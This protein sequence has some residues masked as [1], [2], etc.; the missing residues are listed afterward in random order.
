MDREL[1]HFGAPSRISARAAQGDESR[2]FC[3]GC[4]G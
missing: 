3:D 1:S 4:R 2:A